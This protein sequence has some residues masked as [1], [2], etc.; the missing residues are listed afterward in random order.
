MVTGFNY[1][2]DAHAYSLISAFTIALV[3]CAKMCGPILGWDQET[4]KKFKAWREAIEN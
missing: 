3:F 4:Q 1:L 2:H